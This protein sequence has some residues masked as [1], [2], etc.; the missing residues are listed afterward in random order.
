MDDIDQIT[1]LIQRIN[2]DSDIRSNY[3]SAFRNI[4]RFVKNYRKH[5][6][7]RHELEVTKTLAAPFTR[8][9]LLV[10]LLE[11]RRWHP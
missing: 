11:P 6:I 5:A 7:T 8:R 10:L 3:E 1:A 9:G 2:I 4:V